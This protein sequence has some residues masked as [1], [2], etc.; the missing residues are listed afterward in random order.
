MKKW[1][2]SSFA[3]QPKRKPG[4]KGTHW[5]IGIIIKL[6]TGGI[7]RPNQYEK[8]LHWPNDMEIGMVALRNFLFQDL[9]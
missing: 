3:P 7:S 6:A 9:T 2:Q 5:F 4:G 1:I 8:K